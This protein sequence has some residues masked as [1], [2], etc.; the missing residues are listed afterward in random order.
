M[1]EF[2]C[3]MFF[4]FTQ[5]APPVTCV[6][7][8]L[9]WLHDWAL[10][11]TLLSVCPQQIIIF[12]ICFCPLLD[13]QKDSRLVRRFQSAIVSPQRTKIGEAIKI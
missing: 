6:F 11:S 3:H 12:C 8:V 9:A 10:C 7:V 1:N 5:L 4:L 13:E 2:L